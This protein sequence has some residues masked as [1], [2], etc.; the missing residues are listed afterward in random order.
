MPARAVN[1]PKEGFSIPIKHWLRR[2]LK[3]LLLDR[4]A[5][6]RIRREGI[7]NGETVERLVREH[8]EGRENHSHVLWTML[9]F[10]D[11]R[12]RWSV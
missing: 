3:P 6:D 10:E 2:E 5:P 11:W 9:V 8:L 7:F 4:L 12:E 1:R